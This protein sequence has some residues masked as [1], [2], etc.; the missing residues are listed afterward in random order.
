MRRKRRKQRKIIIITSISL[1]FILTVGYAAFQTNLNITA[2][3]N[4]LEKPFTVQKLKDNFVTSGDG[5]YKDTYESGRFIYKGFEPNN[6]ITFNDE[7]WRIIS[8]ESD[9][10]LKIVKNDDIGIQRYD[11]TGARTTG[12][13]SNSLA[14]EYGCNPWM[15]TSNF[16]NGTFSGAVDKDAELNTFFFLYLIR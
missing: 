10:K 2:K 5:L 12:Y 15:K 16:V 1:L 9:G 3:A 14:L 4:I 8:V 7:L 11:T 6:Y 13:C